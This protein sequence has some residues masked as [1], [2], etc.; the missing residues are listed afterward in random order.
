MSDIAAYER[1]T[2]AASGTQIGTEEPSFTALA[3]DHTRAYIN[4]YIRKL[5]L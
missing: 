3:L 4:V 5:I 1:S 2:R